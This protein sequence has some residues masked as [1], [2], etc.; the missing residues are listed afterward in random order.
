MEEIE[1]QNNPYRKINSTLLIAF[2]DSYY[3]IAKHPSWFSRKVAWITSG[4]PVE[5][6]YAM[7][8]FLSILKIMERCAVLRGRRYL[9]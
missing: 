6:L 3:F 2:D 9:L 7:G 1:L 5:P 4:G 8:S